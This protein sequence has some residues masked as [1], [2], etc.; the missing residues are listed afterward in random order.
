MNTNHNFHE[1]LTAYCKDTID[2]HASVIEIL[3]TYYSE[4]NGADTPKIH[5]LLKKLRL[6]L[7][8]EDSNAIMSTVFELCTIHEECGFRGG[9]NMGIALAKELDSLE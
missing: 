5:A 4:A 1:Y 8:N 2:S 6:Q 7:E 9:L 3:F